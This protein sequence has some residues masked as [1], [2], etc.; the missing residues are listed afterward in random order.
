MPQIR[1][2]QDVDV[3]FEKSRKPRKMKKEDSFTKK[4]IKRDR[5]LSIRKLHLSSEM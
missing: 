3:R 2:G 5:S 1:N 4:K